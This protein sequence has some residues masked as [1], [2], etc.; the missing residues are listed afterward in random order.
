MIVGAMAP[1]F[2]Y[3]I[4]LSHTSHYGHTLRGVF[5]FS[6]PA[7]LIVLWLFHRLFKLPLLSLAP[8]H[9]AR[10]I[11]PDDLRY[12]FGPASRFAWV[13]ASILAG[14]FTHILWD[15]FTHEKG[16]FVTMAPELRLYFGL[17]MPLYSFLQL[18]STV[19]GATL[20]AWGYR[21]WLHRTPERHETVVPQLSIGIRILVIV[22]CLAAILAFA[23]PYG[24]HFA[25]R[26]RENWWSEFIVKSVI[27]SIT[28]GSIE[29]FVFSLN[30]HL[31]KE[32][33][34]EFEVEG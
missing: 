12:S 8:D 29:V 27:A 6:L 28:A 25:N 10:R 20:L 16:L 19:V 21:R 23:L 18:G 34:P 7:G 11:S 22:V 17:H 5:L 33:A 4:L 9:L 31:R 15:D 2:L 3:F 24:L 26:T 30:W 1:D 32:K 14:I 13:T